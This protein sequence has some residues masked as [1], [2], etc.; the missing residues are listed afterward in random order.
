LVVRGG[1][2]NQIRPGA[3]AG[4]H[5]RVDAMGSADDSVT[6]SADDAVT[7][8]ADAV[9]DIVGSMAMLAVTVV[10]FSAVSL[11]VLWELDQ[12]PDVSHSAF[13]FEDRDG[14]LVLR[15][16]GGLAVPLAPMIIEVRD[17]N[18]AETYVV[19]DLAP[20]FAD[21]AW[22]L[23]ESVCVVGTSPQCL[24]VAPADAALFIVDGAVLAAF[25]EGAQ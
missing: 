5:G 20:L 18:G 4:T 12:G 13:R 7:R 19:T 3:A 25:G 22:H 14:R 17:A 24:R 9:T 15:H 23:G 1:G 2:G 11:F 21:P 8:S 6:G 16:V 10:V